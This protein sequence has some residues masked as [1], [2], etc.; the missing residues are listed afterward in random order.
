MSEMKQHPKVFISYSH[1]SQ[2]HVD[3]VLALSNQ[4][5]AEGVDCHIDQYEMSPPE[6]WPRWMLNQIEESDFVL[7]ICTQKYYDRFVYKEEPGKGQ[8]AKWEGTIITQKIYDFE[9]HNTKFVPVLFSPDEAQY[10]PTVLRGP[11][12][13]AL[14]SK[15]GY[16][17]LYRYL[18]DQPITMKPSLG[19]LRSLPPLK[20]KQPIEQVTDDQEGERKSIADTTNLVLLTSGEGG[21]SFIKF[22]SIEVD[23]TIKLMLLPEDS[24]DIAF[25][26]SLQKAERGSIGV[27]FDHK[28]DLA[29]FESGRLIQSGQRKE[30]FLELKPVPLDYRGGSG[31][32]EMALGNYSV[33]KIAEMRARRILLDEKIPDWK[34]NDDKALTDL[35]TAMLEA[36]VQ[37]INTSIRVKQSPFPSLYKITKNNI[38]NF[39]AYAPLLAVLW[40]RL[41]GVVEHIYR[42][43]LNI[44]GESE[45]TVH[46]E[47]RRAQ[48]YANVEPTVIKVEGM[49][50]LLKEE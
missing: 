44:Q 45:L 3:R 43:D 28:A 29:T 16:E 5:R 32:G 2:E 8:G 24:R 27:A 20:R 18:T 31:L 50:Q 4:L 30:Y 9:S 26:E 25:L 35:N 1:D 49:C 17:G 48:A 33:D 12:R 39:L 47:G 41:S 6:G 14:D 15:E 22:E 37:G 13:Y 21:L 40:L 23:K 7:V 19:K 38:S 34:V 11:T 42:L 46:F 36:F 10:I